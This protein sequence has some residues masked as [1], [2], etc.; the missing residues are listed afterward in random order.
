[1]LVT[2]WHDRGTPPRLKT[3]ND[4]YV[5]EFL[6]VPDIWLGKLAHGG[7]RGFFHSA[8]YRHFRREMPLARRPDALLRTENA[9]AGLHAVLGAIYSNK[10]WWPDGLR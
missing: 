7:P 6:L 3:L 5:A 1:V 2:D 9:R 10:L 8:R 4:S